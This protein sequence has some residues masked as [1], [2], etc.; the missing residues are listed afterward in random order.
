MSQELY[1][2][3]KNKIFFQCKN[4][5]QGKNVQ[6]FKISKKFSANQLIF[7]WNLQLIFY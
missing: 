2:M 7:E 4:Q 3:E 1:Y 6:N 5:I